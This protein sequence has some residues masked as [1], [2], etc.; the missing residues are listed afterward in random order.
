ML[1]IGLLVEVL[2][3]VHAVISGAARHVTVIKY[4]LQQAT[5]LGVVSRRT[6]K[7]KKQ[8]LRY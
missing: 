1:V 2:K 5:A 6:K 3:G 8:Q 4:R 7:K